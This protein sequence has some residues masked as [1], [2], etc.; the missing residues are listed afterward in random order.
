MAEE[1]KKEPRKVEDEIKET[2]QANAEIL[3]KTKAHVGDMIKI[4]EMK[5]APQY[6]GKDGTVTRID[7]LGQLRGT[8]GSFAVIPSE[9][10]YEIILPAEIAV[11]M[12]DIMK[13]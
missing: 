3:I 9:D 8:W 6:N 11:P 10:K 2:I 5:D 1:E 12:T 7:G 4:I 13:G